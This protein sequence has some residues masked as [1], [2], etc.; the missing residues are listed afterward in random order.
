V[1]IKSLFFCVDK[2]SV[3][4]RAQMRYHI[5]NINKDLNTIIVILLLL[6]RHVVHCMDS[7]IKNYKSFTVPIDLSYFKLL[8]KAATGSRTLINFKGRNFNYS[9]ELNFS[10]NSTLFTGISF[11]I[12]PLDQIFLTFPFIYNPFH[13]K[14]P[15]P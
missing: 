12:I 15:L 4:L 13:V 11:D 3:C 2:N 10:V 1:Y 9:N 14:S 5:Q 6:F 8:L 7:L